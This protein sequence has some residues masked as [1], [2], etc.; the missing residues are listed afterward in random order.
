MF[1]LLDCWLNLKNLKKHLERAGATLKYL[2]PKALADK[3]Y[4]TFSS[5]KLFASN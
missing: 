5:D 1:P 3:G 2:T 4:A